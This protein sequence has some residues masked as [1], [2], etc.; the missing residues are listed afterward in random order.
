MKTQSAKAKGRKLQQWFRDQLIDRFS[1]SKDDVRSTSMG[2]GGEDILFSKAAGDRLGI[3]IECKSRD[4][5]AVYNFY[6]QAKDNCPDDRQPVV[7]IKQNHSK[8]LAVI[9]AE[10][11]V[12]LL[13]ESDETFGNS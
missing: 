13:K 6:A 1:F 4:S 5:I 12:N 7:I 9:D 10:Y 3:S 11:F 2:A 8:P